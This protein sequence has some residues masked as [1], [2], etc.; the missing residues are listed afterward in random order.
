M[1][2]VG[3]GIGNVSPHLTHDADVFVAVE[4]RVL[5]ISARR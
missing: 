4:K 3:S 1:S 5:V 2:D